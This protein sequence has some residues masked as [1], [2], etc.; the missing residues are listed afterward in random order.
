VKT[1]NVVGFE[2]ELQVAA[3]MRQLLALKLQRVES[4]GVAFTTL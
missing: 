3:Q 4:T 1:R 2:G